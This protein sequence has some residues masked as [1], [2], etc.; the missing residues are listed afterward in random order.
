MEDASRAGD[1]GAALL[2]AIGA[3]VS[4]LSGDKG[5]GEEESGAGGAEVG[6]E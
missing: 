2:Q 4:L 5:D 3:S 6:D 1:A